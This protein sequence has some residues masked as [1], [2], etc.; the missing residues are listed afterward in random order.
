MHRH[1][2]ILILLLSIVHHRKKAQLEKDR[3]IF[4]AENIGFPKDLIEKV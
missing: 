2:L 4:H 1:H 3:A